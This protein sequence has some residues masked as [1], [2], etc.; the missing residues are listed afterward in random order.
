MWLPPSWYAS[1]SASRL[2]LILDRQLED[3]SVVLE[4]A[5]YQKRY[6]LP[7]RQEVEIRR[8]VTWLDFPAR[9]IIR[10]RWDI[11]GYDLNVDIPPAVFRGPAIGG[12][13]QPGGTDSSWT[14][15]LEQAVAAV[16]KPLNQ[17]DVESLRLELQELAGSHALGGLPS[18]RL[19]A[20]SLSD[21][22]RVNRV[23]GLALG[24]GATLRLEGTRIQLRPS[25]GYGTSD[26][27][28]TGEVLGSWSTGAT[29]ISIGA[30]RRID[31]FSDI[32]II[33][34]VLNSLLSQEAGKDHG[35]YVLLQSVDLGLRQR[36]GGRTAIALGLSAEESQSIRTQATPASGT[37]RDNPTL[38]SGTY[39]IARLVLERAS[40]GM[41]V[42]SDLQGRWSVE[43]GDGPSEY[44]RA[45]AQVQWLAGIKGSQL[46]TRFYLGAG[47]PGL[48][49]HRSFVV[50]G[51]GTLLGEPFRKYGGRYVALGHLEWR[52]DVP[53]P[54][55]SLGSFASTGRRI[56]LAPFVAA[57][58]TT[59]P[60]DQLP[61]T[62]TGGVRPVAGLAIELFMRL[63]RVEAGVGLRD[64]VIGV[65]VDVNRD[66]WGLL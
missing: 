36:L 52:R 49:P 1:V 16:A 29:D 11:E 39:G 54:A 51:R 59:E 26:G 23:Q 66:W 60:L 55:L 9:G 25:I 58:Y 47:T 37:Y 35:D 8:R 17:Q 48:P 22:V 30:S 20:R 28:V 4:S 10:G 12:L 46:L 2:L 45:T 56:T 38:G 63:L 7:R 18:K 5:L 57:G 42:R 62:N 44:F 64:G 65:T 33:S 50:G 61:Y 31:D 40:A 13:L 34:P 14:E 3:I 53:V 6:W 27:R 41:A 32:P 15:P 19:A 21:L 24:L 43:V